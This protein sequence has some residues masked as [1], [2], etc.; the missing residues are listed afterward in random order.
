MVANRHLPYEDII[1]VAGGRVWIAKSAK[2]T[3]KVF[4]GDYTKDKRKIN[5]ASHLLSLVNT[6]NKNKNVDHRK[7]GPK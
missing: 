2:E 1:K 6:K 3:G 7:K 5:K 4:I